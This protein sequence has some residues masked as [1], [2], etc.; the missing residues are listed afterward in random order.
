MWLL[1]DKSAAYKMDVFEKFKAVFGCD[2]SVF[3]LTE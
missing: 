2:A 1:R 3:D